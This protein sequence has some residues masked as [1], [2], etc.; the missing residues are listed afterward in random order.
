MPAPKY[1]LFF[2]WS[3]S[4][5]RDTDGWNICTVYVDGQKR[6]SC[7][8]GGYDMQGTSFAEFLQGEFQTELV[9]FA[10][11]ADSHYEL[12]P[13][14]L[15]GRKRKQEYEYKAIKDRRGQFYGMTAY[16]IDGKCRN[17]SLDGGCGFECMCSIAKKLGYGVRYI[18][19]GSKNNSTYL[20]EKE[21]PAQRTQPEQTEEEVLVGLA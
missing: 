6:A 19:T 12:T 15:A 3:V 17:V 18:H 20:M 9:A 21:V 14:P 8:G 5:G 7:N 4:R 11:Q 2:K 13:K 1:S 16:W 10:D